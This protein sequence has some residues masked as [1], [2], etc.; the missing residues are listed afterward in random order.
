MTI[1]REMRR[2]SASTVS[3]TERVGDVVVLGQSI[4]RDK[5]NQR[6]ASK[7]SRNI[8]KEIATIRQEIEDLEKAIARQDP[9]LAP[10]TRAIA[11]AKIATLQRQIA[12]MTGES[13]YQPA[14]S[15]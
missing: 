12:A 15:E 5:P 9:P 11:E 2:R 8:E 14:P 6:G 1:R 3:V 4:S 7:M 10:P 13:G